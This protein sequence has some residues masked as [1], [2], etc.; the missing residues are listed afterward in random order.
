MYEN[1][2]IKHRNHNTILTKGPRLLRTPALEHLLWGLIYFFSIWG[3]FEIGFVEIDKL[4]LREFRGPR[5]ARTV[6]EKNKWFW[7][8]WITT[9]V[10]SRL[11]PSLISYVNISSK[12]IKDLKAKTIK[13]SE[14]NI[15]I[16]LWL[17]IRQDFLTC[18]TRSI[19]NKRKD[20]LIWLRQ[21]WKPLHQSSRCG[22][23]GYKPN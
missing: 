22:W 4:I 10:T 20:R 14:E 9:W 21:N 7:D 5:M 11:V 12:W 8:S 23:A 19:S 18:D 3:N 6:L 13:L 2:I 16:N 17:W 1:K 15:G